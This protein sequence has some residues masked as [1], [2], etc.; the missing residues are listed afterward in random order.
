VPESDLPSL[1]NGAA[2][3]AYP[4]F[5]EGFGLPIVE[6][7]ACGVPVVATNRSSAP[8]I[9][10]DTA[11]LVDPRD[12]EELARAMQALLGDQDRRREIT[13]K[14]MARAQSFSWEKM[15]REMLEAYREVVGS[16]DGNPTAAER[17]D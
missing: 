2:L 1:Y 8:E 5:Y 13:E 15:A 10:Q 3:L 9:V 11:L 17:R 16:G 4:S 12:P 7:M 6:A 14:A